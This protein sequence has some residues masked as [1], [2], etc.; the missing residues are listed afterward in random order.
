MNNYKIKAMTAPQGARL[1]VI[2]DFKTLSAIFQNIKA[3]ADYVKGATLK[4]V[5]QSITEAK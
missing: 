4:S 2:T 5:L 3:G 1:F